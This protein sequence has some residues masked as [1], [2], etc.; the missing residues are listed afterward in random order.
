MDRESIIILLQNIKTKEYIGVSS[1]EAVNYSIEEGLIIRTLLGNFKLS[2][3][4][5][6][7]LN[8]K[9]DLAFL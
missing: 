1:I 3:K 7:F 9:L 4:G 5:E 2:E 6:D 8:G